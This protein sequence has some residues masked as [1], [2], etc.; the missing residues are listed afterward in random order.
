MSGADAILRPTRAYRPARTART[1]ARLLPV[2]L[3]ALVSLFPL[4]YMVSLSF[5]PLGNILTVSAE[6]VPRHPTLANYTGAWQSN[7]FAQYFANSALVGVGTVIGTL[8]LSSL[9]AYG[10]AR[11]E[12]RGREP[13]F[14]ALLAS[15]AVPSVV[16]ILPQYLLMKDLHLVDSL[17]GLILLYISTNLPFSIFLLRGFFEGIPTEL[18]DAMRVDGVS[19]LG[20]LWRL[21]LPLAAPALGAVAIFTFNGAWDE[22]PLAFTMINTPGNRTLPIAIALFQQAHT[23][24]WGPLFAASVIATVPTVIVFVVAQRWFQEGISVGAIQ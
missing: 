9:T 5:Q 16:L 19:E 2:V 22:F 14:Y 10:F 18:E 23:T 11:Y 17:L 24:A 7:D 20:I 12:F 13:L 6:I 21:I 1:V 15:L 3:F 8:V 4:A